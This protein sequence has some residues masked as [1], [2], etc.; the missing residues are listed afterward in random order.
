MI[1]M[2]DFNARIRTQ[3]KGVVGPHGLA[4]GDSDNGKR[5]VGSAGAHDLNIT[6]IHQVT[7]HPPNS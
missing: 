3:L 6:N 4:S 2:R 5:L 7:W 1:V